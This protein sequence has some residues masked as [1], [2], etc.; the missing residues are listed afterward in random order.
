MPVKTW[1]RP[2]IALAVALGLAA[3]PGVARADDARDRPR[4][5]ALETALTAYEQDGRGY[6][7]QAAEKIDEPGSERLTVF[8][9]Q[10][11]LLVRQSARLVHRVWVPLDVVTSASAN[12]TDVRRKAPDVMSQASRQNQAG[13]LD[14]TS[15]Y[16]ARRGTDATLRS[17]FHIEE[18]FRAWTVA[19]GGTQSLADDNATVSGSASHTYDWFDTYDPVGHRLG[20]SSRTTTHGTLG[21]TQ[22]LGPT[23]VAHASYGLSVQY[24]TLG[25]T[26]N[27]VPFDYE[28]RGNED[29]P[30]VRTRHAVSARFA[31]WLPWDGA[32][33]GYHR[34]YA[35][36]WGLVANTT[37]VQLHQRFTSFLRARASYRFHTQSGVDFFTTRARPDAFPRASDSDLARFDA[38]AVGGKVTFESPVGGLR[39]LRFEL[40]FERYWRTDG[41]S[42]NVGLWQTGLRF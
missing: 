1:R 29:L 6:Q 9:P 18:N 11:L 14:W 42:V 17:A 5:L 28:K 22:L 15:T 19:G 38:H 23:T 20:R 21:A 7:S 40:G 30:R 25:N 35:D 41:L 36:D 32:L 39:E 10:I 27:T 34:V 26:W 2:A 31:Q 33:K 12:A 37:E 4:V 24:G 8:S 13:T 16:T 3:L